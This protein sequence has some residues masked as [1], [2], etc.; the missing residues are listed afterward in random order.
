MTNTNKYIENIEINTNTSK[1]IHK[2]TNTYKYIYKFIQ[3]QVTSLFPESQ[4]ISI[5]IIR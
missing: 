2:L 4:N 3:I 5:S 1:Y